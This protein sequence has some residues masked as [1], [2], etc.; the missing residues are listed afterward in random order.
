VTS[1]LEAVTFLS[2]MATIKFLDVTDP[3][4]GEVPLP[5]ARYAESQALV[6][7]LQAYLGQSD[8]LAALYLYVFDK[9]ALLTPNIPPYTP[10]THDTV[11][12]YFRNSF[13]TIRIVSNPSS[14]IPDV[15]KRPGQNTIDI[16]E[17]VFAQFSIGATAVVRSCLLHFRYHIHNHAALSAPTGPYLNHHP[18][19]R[20][21][22]RWFQLL[23]PW[24]CNAS[25]SGSCR[26]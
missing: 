23:P 13:P 6:R 4:V 7:S 10:L 24:H 15:F 17:A 18:P 19:P 3:L 22:A 11:K 26:I 16:P 5:D 8:T 12:A 9:I 20:T 25:R 21:R 1:S 14:T 2:I